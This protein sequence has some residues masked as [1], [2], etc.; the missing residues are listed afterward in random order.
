MIKEARSLEQLQV[1]LKQKFKKMH[2]R[3]GFGYF[4]EGHDIEL[5][6]NVLGQK[7]FNLVYGS[8]DASWQVTKDAVQKYRGR[9]QE[10]AIEQG[11]K[12]L[13]HL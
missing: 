8:T 12:E 1:D 3:K 13:E 2:S 6:N 7:F 10:M 11:K 9:T 4:A 5:G